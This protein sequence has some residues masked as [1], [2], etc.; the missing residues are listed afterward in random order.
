MSENEQAEQV[1]EDTQVD[2]AA[3]NVDVE[4]ADS[5]SEVVVDG[6]NSSDDELD[7]RI[8]RANKEAAK[9]RVEKKETEEKY[10]SLIQNLGKALG[11]VEE[12]D[13]NNAETLAE[14]VTKLQS[15]NR[16]L[17]LMQ[18]FNNVV[19]TEGADDEL[20]WSYLMAKGQLGELDVEDTELSSKLAELV[21]QAIESKPA[22]KNA[23]ASTSVAKSGSDMSTSSQPLDTESR[24][25]QLEADKKM[26]EARAL[27]TQRLLELT[28]EQ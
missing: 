9:F 28:K 13:A 19:K 25:R 6:D 21:K 16:S 24:I 3:E 10:D 23:E 1:Q 22:L 8:Q 2:S 5:S 11:F 4:V 26:K 27:K 14:E 20:T 17:K 7:K 15:E 18:A 12:D